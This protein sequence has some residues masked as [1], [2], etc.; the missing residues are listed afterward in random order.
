[1]AMR[2]SRARQMACASEFHRVAI[3]RTISFGVSFA[4]VQL[5]ERSSRSVGEWK[6]RL[7]SS[8]SYVCLISKLQR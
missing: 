2:S 4:F 3:A 6:T 7:A 8:V 1:M 5:A